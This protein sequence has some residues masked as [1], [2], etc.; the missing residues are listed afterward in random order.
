MCRKLPYHLVLMRSQCVHD[1][2]DFEH[3][4]KLV[5]FLLHCEHSLSLI[6]IEFNTFENIAEFY[7]R[8]GTS[9]TKTNV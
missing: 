4:S 9:K 7:N 5:N 3:D 1:W 2:G 8:T 6:S